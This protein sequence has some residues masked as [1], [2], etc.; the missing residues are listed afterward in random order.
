MNE[1][2]SA[3]IETASDAKSGEYAA[4]ARETLVGPTPRSVSIE[5]N[6]QAHCG[7]GCRARLIRAGEVLS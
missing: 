1:N 5:D 2:Q 3:L 6:A 4:L 7:A